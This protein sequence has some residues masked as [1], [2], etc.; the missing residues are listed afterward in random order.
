[1]CKALFPLWRK[2]QSPRC[3]HTKAKKV[4]VVYICAIAVVFSCCFLLFFSEGTDT[5]TAYFSLLT[6]S[7]FSPLPSADSVEESHRFPGVF[8]VLSLKK[9]PTTLCSN[10]ELRLQ[11][12]VVLDS[13]IAAMLESRILTSLCGGNLI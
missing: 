1:M 7:Y 3:M 8:G 11:C 5:Y 13:V 6:W 2:T 10:T 9:I 12:S 4:I